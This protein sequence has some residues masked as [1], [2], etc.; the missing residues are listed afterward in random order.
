[1]SSN[2][3]IL[4]VYL[5]DIS[6]KNKQLRRGYVAPFYEFGEG[7]S[8]QHIFGLDDDDLQL[9]SNIEARDSLQSRVDNGSDE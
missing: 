4:E 1:M 6:D 9:L 8:I 7:Y 5:K 2:D 3:E